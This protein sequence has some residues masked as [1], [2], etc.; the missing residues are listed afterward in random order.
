MEWEKSH[1][2]KLVE[3]LLLPI[4]YFVHRQGFLGLVGLVL[5]R[6]GGSE[7]PGGSHPRDLK[8][9]KNRWFSSIAVRLF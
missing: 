6:R 1:S 4:N 5:G 9:L 8:M 2:R 3:E 7:G